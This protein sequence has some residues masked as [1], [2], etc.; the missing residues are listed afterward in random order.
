MAEDWSLVLYFE[1]QLD[2]MD[3]LFRSIADIEGVRTVQHR[4]SAALSKNVNVIDLSVERLANKLAQRRLA[5]DVVELIK[6][7]LIRGDKEK[8]G[9][10]YADGDH[11][12]IA[13]LTPSP[14]VKPHRITN[15]Q[16]L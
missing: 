4:K 8:V 9:I 6:S 11:F 10:L 15:I 16:D 7:R 5:R 3:T 13:H 14:A 1:V 2:E 12:D